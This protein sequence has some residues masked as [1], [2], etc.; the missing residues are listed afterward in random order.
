MCRTCTNHTEWLVV[1]SNDDFTSLEEFDQ[2][3]SWYDSRI[4][5]WDN[6]LVDEVWQHQTNSLWQD[7]LTHCCIV[8]DTQASA[9]FHL[10]NRDSFDTTTHN[11]SNVADETT[12]VGLIKNNYKQLLQ[13][14]G[15]TL[16]L[17]LLS[18]AIA[19]ISVLSSVWRL[20][21]SSM[22]YHG[23]RQQRFVKSHEGSCLVQLPSYRR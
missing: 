22:E 19:M 12:I 3:D 17:T 20:Q 18:F 6:K 9:G 10:T 5:Q 2:T 21:R 4:F 23:Q 16:G 1:T 13:G 7:D 8:W 15:I 14:L 11:F